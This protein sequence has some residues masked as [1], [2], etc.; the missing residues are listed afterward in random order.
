MAGGNFDINVGKNRPGTYV[1][2][3]SKRG[4]K[5]KSSTRGIAVL[6]L[7]GYNWGPNGEFIKLLSDSPD[8]ELSKLGHSIYDDNYFMLM[9]REIFK[10]AITCYVYIINSGEAAKVVSNDINITAAYA[11]SRGNDITVSSVVNPIGGF[12]IK[13]YLDTE[14]VESYTGITTIDELIQASKKRYVVFTAE[15]DVKDITAF[16]G[17]KLQGGTDIK[18]DNATVTTFLDKCEG[19]KFNTL[20]FP[21]TESALQTACITK[22]TNLR[23]KTGKMVQAVM[24]NCTSADTEGIINVTNSVVVGENSLTTSQACAWVTGITAAASKTESNTNVE[25]AGASAIVGEKTYEEAEL[26]V[27][28]GEFFFTMSEESKVVVEYD[29]NSLHTF[30]AEKTEDYKKNRVIRVYDSF[31]ESLQLSFPP[32]KFNNDADGWSIMEGLGRALLQQYEVSGAIT[33]VELEDDFFVD[34][35]KSIGDET[36]FNVGLQAVDSAEKL[37]F[38]VS[39]R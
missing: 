15:N 8:A 32:N 13:V 6:P 3:K 25:Y 19:V 26:S 34:K 11:G 38:S 7:V 39:T 29:I 12:D 37:Y 31:T 27:S 23:T 14:A 1:N 16:A 21:I 33:N 30:T 20:C 36:Y 22:I 4:Q 28:K 17:V 9:I 35:S 5:P 10:N 2:V 18:A 24:P